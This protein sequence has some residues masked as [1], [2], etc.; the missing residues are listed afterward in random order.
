MTLSEIYLKAAQ[1]IESNGHAQGDFYSIPESCV[2]IERTRS[3][4]P[5]CAG[6]ALSIALFGDPVPPREGTDGR[7]EFDVAVSRVNARIDNPHLYGFQGEAP[8]MRLAGWNDATERTAADVIALFERTAREV[9][10]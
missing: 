1:V 8:V 5:V 3:E 7:A 2:G 9:A 4:Y 10:A 6:G